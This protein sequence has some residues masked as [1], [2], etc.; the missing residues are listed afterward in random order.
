[1]IIDPSQSE[2]DNFFLLG[3]VVG[4]VIKTFPDLERAN[5]TGFLSKFLARWCG[6]YLISTSVDEKGREAKFVGIIQQPKA[7]IQHIDGKSGGDAI[8][9]KWIFVIRVNDLRIS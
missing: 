9:D 5:I 2:I 3:F 6:A 8:V 4:F 7:R 1:L